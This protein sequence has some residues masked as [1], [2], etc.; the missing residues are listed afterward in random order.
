MMHDSSPR[1]LGPQR[2]LLE[3]MSNLTS[4]L[5]P[6]LSS[7]RAVMLQFFQNLTNFHGPWLIINFW[8]FIFLDLVTVFKSVV[9]KTSFSVNTSI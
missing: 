3:E 1:I 9:G 4:S 5:L 6:N 8:F 7:F 2:Y